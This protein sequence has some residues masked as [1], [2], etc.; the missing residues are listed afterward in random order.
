MADITLNDI[1]KAAHSLE[2]HIVKTPCVYASKLSA[3]LDTRLFLKLETMQHTGSFKDRGA[4][5]KIHSLSAAQKKKGVVTMSAGNHAQGTAWHAKRLG[6]SATIIMPETTPSGKVNNTASYG[7]RIILHGDNINTAEPKAKELA[8]DEGLAFVHPYA[9]PLIIMGQGTVGLELLAAV[10]ELDLIIVPIG[11]GGIISGIAIAAKAI[12]PS[13]KII[14]VEAKLYPSMYQRINGLPP[15]MGGDTIAEGIAVK[16]PGDINVEIVKRLVDDIILLDESELENGICTL[17]EKSRIVAEGAGAAP[18]AA[19]MAYPER[20]KNMNV[21]AVICGANLD[22]QILSSILTRGMLARGQIAYLD[23]S[24]LDMP[25]ALAK[26]SQ[27]I[28]EMQ[29]NI[30]EVTHNRVFHNLPAKRARIG[31]MIETRDLAHIDRVLENL[32][33]VGFTCSVQTITPT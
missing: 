20:F 13:I 27:S 30:I 10:P 28:A 9:D 12:K 23:I 32:R 19:I 6:I 25:G 11:G 7:A 5:I 2:G 31:V 24:I 17:I 1:Q 21:A 22:T 29:A 33:N 15:Q 14:G 18:V 8:A 4:Y 26:I 3:M 16:V